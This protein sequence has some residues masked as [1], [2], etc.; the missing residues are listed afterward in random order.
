MKKK[1]SKIIIVTT[2]VFSVKIIL[3]T[4][5]KNKTENLIKKILVRNSTKAKKT[6][7]KLINKNN[8]N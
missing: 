5:R 8:L 1:M 2:K 4:I 3:L 6:A 7:K